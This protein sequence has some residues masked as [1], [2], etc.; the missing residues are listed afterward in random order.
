MY[1]KGKGVFCFMDSVEILKS[2]IEL[3]LSDM[4]RKPDEY[5]QS[6]VSHYWNKLTEC[7]D[8]FSFEVLFSHV[9]SL[10]NDWVTFD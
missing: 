2:D 5:D 7:S 6:L 4:A 9:L 10:Y 8:V 1:S 3:L